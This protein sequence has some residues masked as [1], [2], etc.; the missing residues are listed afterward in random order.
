MEGANL[1]QDLLS[2]GTVD[3]QTLDSPCIACVVG[4][5]GGGWGWAGSYMDYC[6]LYKLTRL[7]L[8][9]F[10]TRLLSFNEVVVLER[11]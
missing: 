7:G 3:S 11:F 10:L 9:P 2:Q 1:I 5:G 8:A 6:T 4:G